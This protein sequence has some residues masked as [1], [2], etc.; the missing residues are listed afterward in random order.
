MKTSK[1]VTITCLTALTVLLSSA[2][3]SRAD[4]LPA[5]VCFQVNNP[6]DAYGFPSYFDVTINLPSGPQLFDGWCADTDLGISR[7]VTYTAD[8]LALNDP[9]VPTLVEHP[10]NLDK[11]L[12]ILNQRY[13]TRPGFTYGDV[14]RA[15]WTLVDDA[16][17][18]GGLGPFTQANVDLIVAEANASGAGF[19]PGCGQVTGVFL[20]TI[21]EGCD[22]SATTPPIQK[23]LV[24]V[25]IPIVCASIGD[26]VWYDVNQNG[27]QDGGEPGVPNVQVLLKDC[28]GTVLA[29]TTTDANG[30]YLFKDLLPGNYNIEI[31]KS[32]LPAGYAFT[33]Q[34][35]GAD[36]NLDSDADANGVM[37]CTTLVAG[38][39]DLSWDAGIYPLP[40][41]IGDRVW[42]DDNKNGIQDAGEAGVPGVQVL[43]KDCAGTVLATTTT[44]ANG[45]YH[46]TGLPPG[47]YNIEIVKSTLPA[48]YVFTTQNA[49][50]DDNLDS[51]ADANGVMACTTLVAGENDLSWDAGIYKP[52]T[53]PGTGTPGY[54]M[55][56]P[57][58]WPV[59]SITLGGITY[60]K[61][62]AIAIMKAPV[63]GD[64]RYTMF[65][66]LVCAK[67]NVLIGNDSSCIDATIA[68]A[69]AWWATY[70]GS[71]VLAKSYAWQ[72]GG[73]GALA[74]TLDAYNNGLLC[75]PHRDSVQ[76]LSP[77]GFGPATPLGAKSTTKALKGTVY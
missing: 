24:L 41:S 14:Q 62:L 17:S 57:E 77:G 47:D 70:S 19:K 52:A 31:V 16:L 38:E 59:S 5:R 18:T 75:A 55:N 35:A 33:T 9:I 22:L 63:K 7:L 29:T 64:K 10:E 20:R 73:G 69:D 44:D 37:A 60:P 65:P 50:A 66:N 3:S 68:A 45:F 4:T 15:I 6:G 56:H 48:G 12:W 36:D 26:R 67:L 30:N 27:V 32:T 58:A 13:Q 53:N 54:W 23:Q 74:S 25:E 8:V 28:A 46:F 42:F 34:N 11:V 2:N 43:L 49:G 71:L 72:G 21:V 39:N 76:A 40:A 1:L 61:D 51:D